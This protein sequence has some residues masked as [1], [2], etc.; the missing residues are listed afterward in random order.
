[1][2][3]ILIIYGTLSGNTELV[4]DKISELLETK[5]EITLEKVENSNVLDIFNNDI[6]IL[7]CP[8][9][10]NGILLP[11]FIPFYKKLQTTDLKNKDFA[12]IGLGDFKYD[13]DYHLESINILENVIKKNNGKLISDPL[14]IS[15]SPLKLMNTLI[16]KWIENLIRNIEKS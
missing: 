5:Y 1:M 12:I 14:R 2:K 16:P 9:Y 11:Y 10:G 3:K 7:A 15:M 13:M 4:A 6:C 8:T